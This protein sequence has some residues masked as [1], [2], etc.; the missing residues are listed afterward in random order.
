MAGE[1]GTGK[2]TL[3]NAMINY[4]LGVKRED[5]IW[6]EITDDQSDRTSAH[7]QTSRV[8]VYEFYLQ[9]SKTDLT[10][11][12]TLGYGD[13]RGVDLDK[14]ITKSLHS[15]SKSAEGIHELHAVCLVIKA[16]Q[17]RLSDR[18]KYIF[19]AVQ[20]LFGRDF[21]ENI[22]LLFTHSD[23]MHPKNAL[24]AVKEAKIKC[25]VNDKKQP[26][27]F[28]FNNLT[29]SVKSLYQ[30]W[31]ATD[32]QE[33][34]VCRRRSSKLEP[35]VNLVLQN[36]CES[37]L[38]QRNE[39]GS[40][41]SEEICSLHSE[42]LKLL[43]LE[44]KQPVC[45]E[46]VTSQQHINHTFRPISEAV[47]S[48]KEE[49]YT[50]LKSL[51]ENLK[52]K[53]SVKGKYEK[54]EQR[55]KNK[56]DLIEKSILFQDGNP[57]RYRLQT[58]ADNLDQS[59]P[60]RNITFGERDKNKP[61]KTILMAGE[62]E[63][64]KSTL[65]NTMINYMLG[66]KREDKV[67]FEITDD[68][69]DR[70]SA[71]SQTSSVTVY[72]FYLQESPIDLTIIDTP[73]YGDT[74][75]VDLDK[76]IAKSLLNLSKSAEEIHE[77]HAVCLVIKAT[78]NRLSDRQIYIF[79]AVQSL[80]GRDFAENIVLLFT[81][82]DGMHPKNVLTAVK[83]AKI[84][85]AVNDK[86]QPVFFLFNNCQ[87]EPADE[88]YDMIQKQLDCSFSMERF[89]EFLDTVKPKSMHMTLDVLQKRSQLEA[90]I[91][92][93]QSCV[94][95]MEQKTKEL[96]QTQEALEQN[97]KDVKENN[98]FEYEVEVPYKERVDIN[99]AIASVAMCCTFCEENCHYPG[100]WWISGLSLCEVMKDDHCTVCTNKCHYSKHVKSAKI[101]VAKTRKEKRTYEDLKK[102]YD[103]KINDGV[104]LVKK[105]TEELQELEKKK[106]KLLNE[107]FDCVGTLQM[108][109]LNTDS[110]FTLQHI[111]FL[112]EKLKEFDEHEK[113]KTLEN[114]GKRAGEEKQ[115]ALGYFT[116]FK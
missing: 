35:S 95:M 115:G 82:S 9:E 58:S 112:I 48:Y 107:A 61:H 22:V 73:G 93:L 1:T 92:S 56:N 99:Q 74:R 27:F 96:K 5:K 11:I 8:T 98:N 16:S 63:T 103:D 55:I 33:C 116:R 79:D 32:T 45:V 111:D 12:D 71:H 78:Q 80:F 94:Q 49:L 83:E 29:V 50:P 19:D 87:S 75:G 108:I 114:I 72:E 3:I 106:T 24:T 91:S 64:G 67:W 81:H 65:I 59:E 53:E 44:D 84:Q 52:H 102:K 69:S 7:S 31:R 10:I 34:P 113:A 68:Q 51:Q 100:C 104:S 60:Y 42:K 21:A 41:G 88:E 37:F 101:Y 13:T 18:Q 39:N 109:S 77:I 76:D 40:S 110:L 36:L 105:M 89:F 20:S 62:I 4:M 85:C 28:L 30:F 25:A 70:T 2:S 17:N 97:K 46:C 23:G 38:K 26:V 6:F 14:D 90:N 66:V 47:P 57:A 15:L 43:C 54:T 86:K